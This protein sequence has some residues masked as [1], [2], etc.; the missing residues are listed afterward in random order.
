VPTFAE[1]GVPDFL[2]S[3]WVG[4]FAPQ[5][6]SPEITDRLA[7]EAVS[8]MATPGMRTYAEGIG[9][10]PRVAVGAEL[11]ALMQSDSDRWKAIIERIG[12]VPQ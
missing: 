6:I 1:T 12:L 9:G 11:A 8:I 4:L 5:G 2:I 7:R 10:E 3:G